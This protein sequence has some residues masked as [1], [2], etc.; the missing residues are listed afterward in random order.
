MRHIMRFEGTLTRWD[1]ARGFGFLE[2]TQGGEP[3][4]VHI[5]AIS[6][7]DGRPQPGQRFSFEVALGPQGKKRATA[8]KPLRAATPAPAPRRAPRRGAGSLGTASMLVLPAFSLLALGVAVWWRPPGWLLWLY[9]G[10]SV[11][12]FVLYA[13]D[14]SAAERGDWRVSERNL[15]LVSLAG[16]WPGAL[17]AQQWL[18]H[19]TLKASFRS[20]FWGTVL[21]NVAALVGG[22]AWLARHAAG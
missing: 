19:K 13:V 5:R 20:T 22:S 14:K 2:S 6:G 4:W 3:I 15:H 17:L 12:A 1:D 18:R 16:G 10:A 9:A 7:L 21:A 11:L 8:V